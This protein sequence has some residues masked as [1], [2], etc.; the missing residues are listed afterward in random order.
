[1]IANGLTK[2]SEMHQMMLYLSMGFRWQIIFDA[3]RQ[4]EKQRRKLGIAP[5][6]GQGEED[7]TNVQPSAHYTS[8]IQ[9]QHQNHHSNNKEQW[10]RGVRFWR[11][12]LCCGCYFS[13]LFYK[14]GSWFG[15]N[16]L[17]ES[18][19][20]IF[21]SNGN[22]IVQLAKCEVQCKIRHRPCLP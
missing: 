4:S 5:M 7:T 1:M 3:E 11:V 17:I 9:H 6:E 18:S 12:F 13:L 2:V 14:S 21:R 16:I 8:S 22:S 15:R 10:L 20:E 19:F